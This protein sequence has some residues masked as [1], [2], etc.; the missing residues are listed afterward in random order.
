MKDKRDRGF[1]EIV[2]LIILALAALK[3]FLDW[4]IF[5]AAATEEGQGTISYIKKVL[6]AIWSYIG[7]PV[8]WAWDKVFWPI[9]QLGWESLQKFIEMGKDNISAQ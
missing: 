9:L 1:I 2:I 3:Y 6:D 5:D 8:T 7:S 4:D